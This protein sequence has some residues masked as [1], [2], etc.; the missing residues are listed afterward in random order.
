VA[1]RGLAASRG[2]LLRLMRRDDTWSE[3]LRT[4]REIG[5]RELKLRCVILTL[6]DGGYSDLV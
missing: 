1:D 3:M 5:E 2:R 4:S 6:D